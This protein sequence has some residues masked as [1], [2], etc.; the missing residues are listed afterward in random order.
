MAVLLTPAQREQD[1]YNM[2]RKPFKKLCRLSFL[3]PDGSVA[4]AL[5][6]SPKNPRNKT[7]IKE[8]NL[9]V[10]LQNGARRTCSVKLAN[11]NGEY[12]YNVN[13]IWFGQEILLEEGLV[14]SD[15][16][17][18][19]KKQGVFVINTPQENVQPS[20][21][22]VTFNL[23]DKW[24]NI[25]GT[26]YGKLEGTYE[27]PTDTNIFEPIEALLAEDRGNGYPVDR[28]KPIFTEYYNGKT[29]TLPDGTVKNL[30]ESPY[31]LSVSPSGT[32][33]QVIL[34]L[35]GMVNGLIGYDASGTLRFDPSQD[36]ILDSTKP[37][38]WQFSQAETSLIG[39]TYTV[40]NS[41]VYNDFIVVGEKLDDNSQP[42]ARAQN[43][44][45][46]SDTNINLIG[47]KTFRM[48]ASGFAT[49]QQCRDMAEWKLKRATVLQK[50]VSISCSQLF[51]I[52]EG[53]L[54][55][56]VRT[57]KKGSPVERHFIQG[58]SRPLASSGAMTINCVSTNDFPIA[59]VTEW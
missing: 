14:L 9:N 37:V 39:L 57:D 31:T 23:V 49:V 8:G 50:A 53:D 32:Y 3:Q 27:V 38:V 28:V 2:L 7:F 26:M 10:N 36:D 11:V 15:G 45:P 47:R 54:V 33:A 42:A 1:Y 21:R 43:L 20:E 24:A 41:E 22:T 40:K 44:D 19:Y 6:N 58:F 18:F 35:A 34:E 25:D 55:T 48:D 29:Q 4:F 12:D 59:T 46:S 52:N 30:V 56:I 51:H 16:S 13:N 17:E 5:D